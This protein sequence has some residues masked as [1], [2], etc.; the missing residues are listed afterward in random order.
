M[1]KNVDDNVGRLLHKLDEL[2][3]SENTIVVFTSDNG[4]VIQKYKDK[5]VTDNFPLREGK[6]SLYEGGIVFQL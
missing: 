1:V 5:V 3:I 6:G 4:G 2:G